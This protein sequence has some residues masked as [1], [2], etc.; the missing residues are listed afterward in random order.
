MAIFFPRN[1]GIHAR[2]LATAILVITSST[3]TLGYSGLSMVKRLV[4]DRFDQQIDYMTEQLAINAELGILIEEN[5]LLDG[6]AKS[7]LNEK[8]VVG[9]EIT[10]HNGR[11]IAQQY[12]DFNSPPLIKEKEVILS[13]SDTDGVDLEIMAGSSNGKPIGFVRIKYT[14]Q[15]IKDLSKTMAQQFVFLSLGLAAISC[16][17]FFLISRSLVRPVISLADVA[18]LISKGNNT[19]RAH[20]GTIPETRRLAIAFNEMLDSIDKNRKALIGAQSRLSRQ[21]ALAEVGKFSMMIAHEVKNPLAIMKSSLYMLKK[22]LDIP[23]DNLLLNYAEEELTRLNT[24]IESFLMF[25]RPTKPKLVSTDINQVVEQVILGFKLQYDPGTLMINSSIPEEKC[26]TL[27]DADLLARA[28]SNIIR[29][30]CDASKNIGK[31][32][33]NI[34]VNQNL[35]T[36]SVR[37]YGKG[38]DP[39]SMDKLFEP[40]YTTKTSGTGLGL[41]FADQVAKAHGGIITGENHG[42]SGAVFCVKIPL[43][44][45]EQ[46]NKD[47]LTN[48]TYSNS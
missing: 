37:D 8:D 36:L 31:I 4:S 32:D 17:I 23:D 26:I 10:D 30:A 22:D 7:V 47:N 20:L 15:G 44:T 41:A 29:N 2:L 9:V 6:L 14:R 3:I 43:E 40:F 39:K 34:R 13:H 42:I 16:I 21:E 25:A 28:F 33:I 5:A 11:L 35:W 48:G 24:L 27:A 19:V 12:R 18:N 1:T 46:T 38:I 45:L